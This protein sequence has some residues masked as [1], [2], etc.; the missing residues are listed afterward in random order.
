M[1]SFAFEEIE[2]RVNSALISF[3]E[4]DFQ[5]L[6]LCVDE[7]AATHRIACYLQNYF[8]K[9][10]V[11]CEYNRRGEKPKVQ[12]ERL[13]RPDI[14]IHHRNTQDNL[15]CIEAKKEGESLEDD[16]IKL[17]NFTDPA[18]KDRYLFGL[19]LVF[20]MKAPYNIDFEWFHDGHSM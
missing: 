3:R 13:V 11:D 1:N 7:R 19:L 8:T 15:L 4:Q 14:I 18:G 16:R 17:R 12:S 20:S 10:H 6:E 9:W 5:L 2:K